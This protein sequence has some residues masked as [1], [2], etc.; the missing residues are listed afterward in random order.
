MRSLVPMMVI[1]TALAVCQGSGARA[2]WGS[3]ERVWQDDAYCK[4]IGTQFG[5]LAYHECRLA[6]SQ[7]R[8]IRHSVVRMGG[9][10]C[11]AERRRFGAFIV[12][13]GWLAH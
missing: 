8:G 3:D 5:T 6:L 7:Q 13:A 1:A 4:S 9:P 10:H 2:A 11:E 12:R